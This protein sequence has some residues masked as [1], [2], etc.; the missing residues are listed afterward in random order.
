MHDGFKNTY[1]LII[2][3]EKIVLNPLPPNQGHK[4]K[5]RVG[6]EKKRDI[7]M[8]SETRVERDLSKGKQ[9]L[10]LFMLESNKSKQ[11][12]PLH[13]MIHPLISQYQDVFPQDLPP[14]SNQSEALSTKLTSFLVPYFQTKRLIDVTLKRLKSFKDKSMNCWLE[15]M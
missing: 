11:V 10:A 8:L 12:P 15:V 4:I 9:V 13:L 2:D 6:S 1:S 3:K 5:P 14:T 7:L